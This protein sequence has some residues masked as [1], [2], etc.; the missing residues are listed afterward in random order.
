MSHE[1]DGAGYDLLSFTPKGEERLLEIKTTCGHARTPFWITLR[2][3]EVAIRHQEIY[4]VRRVFHFRNKPQ[5][6]ELPP[7]LEERVSLT[8]TCYLASFSG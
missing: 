7:P 3:C 1:D 2:E 5:M 8:P 6:F 4:R